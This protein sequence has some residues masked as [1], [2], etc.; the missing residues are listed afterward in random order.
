MTTEELEA[1]ELK[2]KAEVQLNPGCC[3]DLL[4]TTEKSRFNKSI[5][6]FKKSAEKYKS[7]QQFRKAGDIYE[8]CAEIKINLKENPLEFYNES[9]SCYENIYII[10]LLYYFINLNILLYKMIQ[11][12]IQKNNSDANVKKIFFKINNNYEKKGEYLEAGKN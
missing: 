5:N 9:I 2:R 10:C 4:C 6:L 12:I 8:K 11:N 3:I 1:F 7:L